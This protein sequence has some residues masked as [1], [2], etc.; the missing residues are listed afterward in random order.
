MKTIYL[1]KHA[2]SKWSEPD[3]SDVER[4]IS[5]KGKKDVNAIGSYLSLRG[6]LPDAILSSCA[7]RAARTSDLLAKKIEY[8]GTISYL[9]ELYL[10]SPEQIKEI[11]MAQDDELETIFVVGHNPQ[12]TELVNSLSDERIS[13]LP[14]LGVVAIDFDVEEWSELED[15]KGQIDFFIYPKQFKYYMP[16]Q[17]RTTLGEA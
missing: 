9:E 4:D 5:K 13:K 8:R 10:T 15:T 2:K 3:I 16:K 1:I 12:L 17:I 6:V 7:L 14:S 11:V